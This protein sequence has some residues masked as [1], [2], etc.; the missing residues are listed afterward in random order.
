MKKIQWNAEGKQLVAR[1]T[2]GNE[3]QRWDSPEVDAAAIAEILSISGCM[4]TALSGIFHATSDDPMRIDAM[5]GEP[6]H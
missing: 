3:L 1:D 4:D 6:A 5:A 2:A